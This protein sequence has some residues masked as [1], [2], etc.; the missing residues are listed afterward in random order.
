MKIEKV[1]E[2]NVYTTDGKLMEVG[3][4]VTFESAGKN[5]CGIYKGI[6]K[7]GALMFGSVINGTNV[8]FNILPSSI[9]E[10]FLASVKLNGD[11][12]EAT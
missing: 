2:I 6:S 9:D 4:I 7:K 3:S 1:T 8:T 11:W 5:F 12:E 10:I